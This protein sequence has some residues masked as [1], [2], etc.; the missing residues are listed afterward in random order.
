[1]TVNGKT[2]KIKSS[3]RFTLFIVF[4]ILFFIMASNTIIGLNDA[5]S[6]TQTEYVEVTVQAGDTL[7]NIAKIYNNDENDIRK[8]V[9]MI[10]RIN[11]IAA[12]ELKAGQKLVIP[13]N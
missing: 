1:M 5:S 7:W 10:C 13:V 12:H 3:S 4:V 6:L 2:Y 8:S 11:D 9:Y